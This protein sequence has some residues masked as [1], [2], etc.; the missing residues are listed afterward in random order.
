MEQRE[1]AFVVG[2][3]GLRRQLG[4]LRQDLF[5]VNL[6]PTGA[7]LPALHQGH[8]FAAHLHPGFLQQVLALLFLRDGAA[9]LAVIAVPAC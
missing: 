7:G 1:A 6:Q 2:Q 3:L 9:D 8:Q 5:G 4:G